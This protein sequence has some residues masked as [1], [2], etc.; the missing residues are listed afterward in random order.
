MIKY[1]RIVADILNFEQF[2]G[3]SPYRSDYCR[4]IFVLNIKTK[5]NQAVKNYKG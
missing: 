1:K 3:P 2:I 5:K 4:E